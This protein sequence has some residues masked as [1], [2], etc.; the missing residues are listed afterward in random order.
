MIE[1]RQ[2]TAVL[3]ELLPQTRPLTT[4]KMLS[5]EG[6]LL[7]YEV[8]LPEAAARHIGAARLAETEYLN[9]YLSRHLGRD[10]HIDSV[11]STRRHDYSMLTHLVIKT[12]R[13]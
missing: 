7:G 13:G 1:S 2:I 6:M 3:R 5:S 11:W 8:K 10:V 9:G 4:S 12:G